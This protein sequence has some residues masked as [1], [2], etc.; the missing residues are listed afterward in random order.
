[1]RQVNQLVFASTN[2][3]KYREFEALLKV[4]PGVT[5]VSAEAVLRNP[6]K[7]AFVEKYATYLE[8]AS[9]KARL[10]NQGC[11]YP[12]F[13]DDTGLEVEALEGR[14]GVH[15]ARFASLPSLERSRSKQDEANVVKLLGEM[16]GQANRNARFVSTV[17]LMV[18][19]LLIHGT[20]VLEGT[21][22]QEPRGDKGFGYDPIFI[23]KGSDRTLAEMSETEKNAI[24]HRARALQD[25]ILQL[26]ARG[27]ILAKP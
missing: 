10:A 8:N 19:G 12:C 11:H 22:A 23:P 14:P 17:A 20:G 21:L 5:L 16:K 9:A 24:S 3:D 26:Q 27:V 7:L 15:T 4:L 2:V 1:M 6:H 25:L 18:E 13:A